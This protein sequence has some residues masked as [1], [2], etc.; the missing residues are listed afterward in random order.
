M[1]RSTCIIPDR[2]SRPFWEI[3]GSFGNEPFGDPL[4]NIPK[5][6]HSSPLRDPPKM[7]H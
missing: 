1:G 5:R 7:G 4:N 6:F 2:L 3:R